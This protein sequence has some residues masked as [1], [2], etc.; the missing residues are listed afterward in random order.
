[1]E[2]TKANFF[3]NA[4]GWVGCVVLIPLLLVSLFSP[5]L[6]QTGTWVDWVVNIVAFGVFIA[7][8]TIRLWATLYIGGR[9]C[10]CV[11]QEGP[12]SICRNPLYIGSFLIA[13]SFCLFLK[14]IWFACGLGLMF[15][16]YVLATIP[17]EERKLRE[18]MGAEYLKYCQKVPRII[19]NFSIFSSASSVE[20]NLRALNSEAKRALWYA[21]LPMLGMTIS[22]LRSEKW[23]PSLF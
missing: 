19:P 8:A 22:R 2:W 4:R 12:Y 9:K 3:F 10:V 18:Q 13:F 5:P 23:W 7:G 16:F 1:M 11:V 15:G 17:V 20:L 21:W 6:I 14:T